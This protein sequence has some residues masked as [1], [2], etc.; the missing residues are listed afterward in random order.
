M[1]D[2][3]AQLRLRDAWLGG[4]EDRLCGREQAKAWALRECWRE[5]H[6]SDHGLYKFVAARVNKTKDGLPNG[7]NPTG[8]AVKQLFDKI[9]G[10]DEWFPGKH[11]GG[12]R[13]PQPILKGGKKTGLI[14]AAK[15]IKRDGG[16][17]TYTGLIANA[18]KATLNPDTGEPVDRKQVFKALRE[19]APDA[20]NPEEKWDLHPR[21]TRKA[22][23]ETQQEKRLVWAKWIRDVVA[24]TAEWFFMNLVWVDL[25]NSI[26]PRTQK[27]AT[28]QALARRSDKFWGLKSEQTHSASLR[29]DRKSL[30]MKPKTGAIRVWFVPILARGKFHIEALPEEFP[31]ETEA[32][33]AIMVARVRAALNIRFRDE[34]PT[35][36]FTDRGNGFFESRSGKMTSGYRDA[37]RE[38]GLKAFM[39]DG[40]AIQPGELQEVMLHETAMA[41]VR[42]RLSRTVPR[43]AW[44]ETVPE[45]VSRLKQVAAYIND[46]YNVEG[47]NRELPQRVQDLIDAEG[48]RIKQ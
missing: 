34:A 24:L 32:G 14:Q 16:E 43:E 9:D 23:T 33:A 45:Y 21:L 5:E 42:N 3:D 11:C 38:H 44:T 48:D 20:N 37:L 6:D 8:D 47:L 26:L 22:L 10:D 19:H 28:E 7:G 40:A 30:K 1:A 25:C 46:N 39:Q 2:A 12:K 35:I 18:P 13:G 41:W 31:G 4:P 27:F 17:I 15:K 36:L 29:G